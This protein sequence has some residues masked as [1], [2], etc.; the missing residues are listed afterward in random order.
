MLTVLISM[1]VG[2]IVFR[3]IAKQKAL[4]SKPSNPAD[5]PRWI[6]ALWFFSNITII[7]MIPLNG[8]A[9]TDFETMLAVKFVIL[10]ISLPIGGIGYFIYKFAVRDDQPKEDTLEESA[11]I[12]EEEPGA[13]DN[14]DEELKKALALANQNMRDSRH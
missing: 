6:F 2:Y 14:Y 1:G 12:I 7:S 9:S 5:R 3:L 8:V 13:E 10:I 4:F 11:L